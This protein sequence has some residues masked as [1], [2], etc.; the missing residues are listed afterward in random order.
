VRGEVRTT[1][2]VDL[3]LA[4]RDDRE[5]EALTAD[6][7]GSG[8]RVVA[9]VEQEERG[10]LA[11]VRLVSRI[12]FPV[13]LLAA[14]SGIEP[15]IVA[16]AQPV[17]FE[18]AGSIPVALAEDL[19]AMKLLSARVGRAKDWDDA[20]GLF[21]TNPALDVAVVRARLQLITDRGFARKQDL[22]SKLEALLEEVRPTS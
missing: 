2:D 10:R 16:S 13:D 19:L 8:Y 18:I 15:E 12:G 3:A 9:T 11:T 5:V 21:E 7:M 6:L 14:S 17:K 4:V 1:R 22:I 20:R